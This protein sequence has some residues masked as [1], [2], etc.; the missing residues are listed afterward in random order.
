M[1]VCFIYFTKKIIVSC[2]VPGNELDFF[3]KRLCFKIHLLDKFRSS[4]LEFKK[5]NSSSMSV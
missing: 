2:L 3:H 1:L 5:V 4:Y